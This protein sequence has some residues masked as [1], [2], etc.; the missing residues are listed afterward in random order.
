V[1][2]LILDVERGILPRFPNKEGKDETSVIT[3]SFVVVA[4]NIPGDQARIETYLPSSKKKGG[5]GLLQ[6]NHFQPFFRNLS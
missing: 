1:R 3:Q 2:G 4:P 6:N 5:G